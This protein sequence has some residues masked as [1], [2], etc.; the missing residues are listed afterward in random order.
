MTIY[1]YWLKKGID[2]NT[3]ESIIDLYPED[4]EASNCAKEIMQILTDDSF[5]K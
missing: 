2:M 1:D 4:S 3:I 5:Q